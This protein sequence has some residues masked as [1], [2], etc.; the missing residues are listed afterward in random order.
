MKR[1]RSIFPRKGKGSGRYGLEAAILCILL[2]VAAYVT[3]IG[4]SS[5]SVQASSSGYRQESVVRNSTPSPRS[6]KSTRAGSSGTSSEQSNDKDYRLVR[7]IDGDSFVLA[8]E[9]N[10]N[11]RVRLYGIDAP[12]GRQRFG[13]ASREN[14]LSLLK[15]RTLRLKTLYKDSFKRSVAI[16]YLSSSGTIDELSVNQRQVQSGM[17][18]VYDSFCTADICN[19]WKLEEAMARKQRLGLW[20]DKKPT[21]PW[22]WRRAQKKR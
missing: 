20:K 10:R 15:N 8:D 5:S 21:P 1:R 17:A 12:E 4:P 16:V 7:I 3:N 22:E 2:L 14:L 13:N 6:A 11:V 18:W 9:K 19:T